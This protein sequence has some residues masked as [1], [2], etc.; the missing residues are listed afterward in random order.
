MSINP[1]EGLY[2]LIVDGKKCV[3][4][5]EADSNLRDTEQVPLIEQ[6]GIEAFFK[7]EVLPYAADAWVDTSKTQ[8]GYE[9]SFTKHFYKAIKMRSLEE[10]A[11]EIQLVE[12]E[13]KQLFDQIVS[14]GIRS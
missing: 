3:V 14:G 2:E 6:G 13:S 7:R 9:I 5:Y 10:I 11:A 4:E 1:L 8:I 12:E